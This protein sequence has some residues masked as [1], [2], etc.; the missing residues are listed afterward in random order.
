VSEV[1]LRRLTERARLPFATATVE[2]TSEERAKKRLLLAECAARVAQAKNKDFLRLLQQKYFASVKSFEENLRILLCR[3]MKH[4]SFHFF[5]EDTS[6]EFLRSEGHREASK[7]SHAGRRDFCGGS[8][9]PAR[10]TERTD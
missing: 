2:W 9:W 1:K 6:D 4:F 3:F 10:T 8:S 7:A 5:G